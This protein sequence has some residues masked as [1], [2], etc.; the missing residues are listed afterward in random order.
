MLYNSEDFVSPRLLQ[1]LRGAQPQSLSGKRRQEF[2][3]VGSLIW[4]WFE[5]ESRILE[6]QAPQ[7][8][9]G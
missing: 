9:L 4:L 3:P 6:P 7:P 2:G 8:C 1:L 5:G